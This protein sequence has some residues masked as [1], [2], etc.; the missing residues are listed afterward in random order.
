M[1]D[2]EVVVS[3][4]LSLAPEGDIPK[5]NKHEINQIIDNV[6]RTVKEDINRLG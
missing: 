3:P 2:C 6:E 4:F 5:L 1:C